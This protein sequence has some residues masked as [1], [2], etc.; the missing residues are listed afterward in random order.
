MLRDFHLLNEKK[1]RGL[2]YNPNQFCHLLTLQSWNNYINVSTFST[3][4][5]G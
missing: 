5:W 4:E 3:V 1:A 2:A